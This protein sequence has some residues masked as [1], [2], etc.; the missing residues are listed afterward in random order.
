M[1]IKDLHKDIERYLSEDCYCPNEIYSFDGFFYMIF[2]AED[3]C[4]LLGERKEFI[5]CLEKRTTKNN[6]VLIFFK[7]ED[8]EKIIDAVRFDA[9]DNNLNIVKEHLLVDEVIGTYNFNEY[10]EGE[11]AKALKEILSIADAVSIN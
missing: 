1:T 3:E 8:G 6:Q 2:E 10:K 7:S 5:I 9:T 4:I 11:T